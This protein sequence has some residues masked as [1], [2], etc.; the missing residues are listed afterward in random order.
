MDSALAV[1]CSAGNRA[2]SAFCNDSHL[3][4]PAFAEKQLI[5][6]GLSGAFFPLCVPVKTQVEMLSDPQE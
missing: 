4:G 1:Q 6:N 5:K 2:R 3:L